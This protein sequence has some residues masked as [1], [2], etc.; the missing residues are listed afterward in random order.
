MSTDPVVSLPTC[1]VVISSSCS[2]AWCSSPTNSDAGVHVPPLARP[3]ARPMLACLQA[4][5]PGCVPAHLLTHITHTPS[6]IHSLFMPA[7]LV[8]AYVHAR[9]SSGHS[10]TSVSV[11]LLPL[12]ACFHALTHSALPESLPS[13]SVHHLHLPRRR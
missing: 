12:S 13:H 8:D 2:P 9:R 6:G 7:T 1:L 4:Q 3:H 11:F 5:P 10:P